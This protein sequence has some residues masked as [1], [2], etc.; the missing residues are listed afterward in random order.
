MNRAPL[1]MSAVVLARD[2]AATIERTLASLADF[3]EVVVYDNGSTDATPEIA[4]RFANVRVVRG[5]FDG[6]ASTRTRAGQQARHDW[7]FSIDSDEWLTPELRESLRSAPLADPR[8]VITV[9]GRDA[10]AHVTE[11][12]R[13]LPWLRLHG[14]VDSLFELASRAA[15]I[16]IPLPWGGGTKLKVVEALALGKPLVTTPCGAEGLNITDEAQALIRS[17]GTAFDEAADA[18]LAAPSD[19]MAMAQRGRAYAAEYFS[20]SA[21]SKTVRNALG[22]LP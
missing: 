9:V 5:H 17:T 12:A 14:F 3:P 13:A 2:A 22:G 7:V 21:L 8:L 16:I 18:V 1:A 6:F 11:Q 10:P 19:Y 15:A 20:Q 4:G